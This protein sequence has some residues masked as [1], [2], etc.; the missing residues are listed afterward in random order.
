VDQNRNVDDMPDCLLK[1]QT[2]VAQAK[3]R[4]SK[5]VDA[6]FPHDNSSLGDEVANDVFRKGANWVS[7]SDQG[8]LEVRFGRNGERV[9][10]TEKYSI[11]KDGIDANDIQQGQLGDCYYLSALAVLGAA[12]TR[13]RFVFVDG[14]DEWREC[15]AFCIRFYAD[16]KEDLVIVD[17]YFPLKDGDYPF[18]TSSDPLELWPMVLEKAY[19]KR[20]GSFA[21][22]AGGFPD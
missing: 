4:R 9:G 7:F 18:V 20:Y 15:G 5:F 19:A 21:A 10:T 13:A 2:I 1:Y 22:I 16:G 6:E 3:Q 14:E 12:Q 8:G 11:F 17:D